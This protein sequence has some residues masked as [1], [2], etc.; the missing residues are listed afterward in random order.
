MG[1]GRSK[2]SSIEQVRQRGIR[3]INSGTAHP[4]IGVNTRK[5]LPHD[6]CFLPGSWI[7]ARAWRLRN[8]N[9]LDI[10]GPFSFSHD[11]PP[12]SLF[13]SAARR[14]ALKI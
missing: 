11:A 7:E 6:F 4:L 2:D 5:G 9:C 1:M 3:G 13:K 8:W 10:I 12:F 14:A